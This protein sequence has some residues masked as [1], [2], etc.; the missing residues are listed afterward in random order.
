MYIFKK[1]IGI[2]IHKLQLNLFNNLVSTRIQENY[3]VLK[4]KILNRTKNLNRSLN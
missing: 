1:I 4:N 3:I 2:C